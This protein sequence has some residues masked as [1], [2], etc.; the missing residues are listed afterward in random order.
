M[1]KIYDAEEHTLLWYVAPPGD[2]IHYPLSGH[3]A[4]NVV[5]PLASGS[6]I[7]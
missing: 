2:V 1:D 6:F 4:G 5:H 7:S 3:P